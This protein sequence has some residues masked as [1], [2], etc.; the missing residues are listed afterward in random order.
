MLFRSHLDPATIKEVSGHPISK[1]Y[2]NFRDPYGWRDGYAQPRI[3]PGRSNAWSGWITY[4]VPEK[5]ELRDIQVA[6]WFM[7]YGTAY[8]NLVPR[9]VVQVT[10]VPA[11]APVVPKVL[12]VIER[13]G[14][15]P[16]SQQVS[17][18]QRA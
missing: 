3:E 18:R 13:A 6:G 9:E 4:Q 12:Q 15:R 7:N 14:E 17:G 10:Q 11:P 16:G 2:P 1:G 8:W 5:A